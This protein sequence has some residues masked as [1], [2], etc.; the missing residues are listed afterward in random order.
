MLPF[1]ILSSLVKAVSK[2]VTCKIRILPTV[3]EST[4]SR[5]QHI[6]TVD[7]SQIEETVSLAKMIESTGVKALAVHGR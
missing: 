2:P 1:K 4:Y 6:I 3:S 7:Q 5:Q